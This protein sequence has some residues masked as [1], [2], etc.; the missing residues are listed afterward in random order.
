MSRVSQFTVLSE[1]ATEREKQDQKWGV[2]DHPSV[3]QILL[4]RTGGCTGQRMCE[5]YEIPSEARAKFLLRDAFEN[6]LGTWTHIALEELSEIVECV[7]DVVRRKEIVQ[8]AAVCVAWI[9]CI[10]RR[11]KC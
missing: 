4:N 9:E 7:D 10:D 8:L 6:N 1:I 2:Q 3:D 5:N 11:D